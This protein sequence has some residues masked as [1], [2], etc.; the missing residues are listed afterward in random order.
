MD[1]IIT[2]LV[3]IVLTRG[4]MGLLFDIIGYWK[5]IRDDRP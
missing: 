5:W 1:E 2:T 4:V 3:I